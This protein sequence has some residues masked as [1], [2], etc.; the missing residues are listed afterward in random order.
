M[1]VLMS[2]RRTICDGEVVTFA[3][4]FVPEFGSFDARGPLEVSASRNCVMVHRAG[5]DTAEKTDALL[6]AIRAAER[7]R[8]ALEPT[9]RGVH[10]SQY[11]SEPTIVPERV[12]D[13]ERE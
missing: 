13:G 11:P 1:G 12:E 5:C 8:R 9:W 10:P 4:E 3:T 6:H 7:V 2:S